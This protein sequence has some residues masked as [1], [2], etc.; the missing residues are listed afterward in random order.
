M[1][2]ISLEQRDQLMLVFNSFDENNDERLNE[3][4]LRNLLSDFE[5]DGNFAPVMLRI[6]SRANKN[7]EKQP[8]EIDGITFD[9][10]VSFFNIM[11]SGNKKDFINL[12]FSAIDF[13]RDGK[14]GVNELI[15]FSRLIGD[16][17]TIDEAKAMITDC[18]EKQKSQHVV[19]CNDNFDESNF[20]K[21]KEIKIIVD[22]V[23]NKE[24]NFD[25]L[26]MRY[27]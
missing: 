25:Q 15:E 12:I 11:L 9:N 14:V 24:I 19:L 3:N 18:L 22:N 8:S 27:T 10:F 6:F 16:S 23:E 20:N 7:S 17:L 5:I 1:D 13:D 21:Y 26:W 4:E 2:E